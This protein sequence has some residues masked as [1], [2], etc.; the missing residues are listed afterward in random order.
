MYTNIPSLLDLLSIPL[1]SSYSSRSPQ[2]TELSFLWTF[3]FNYT[4][5]L[6]LSHKAGITVLI[7]FRINQM[8]SCLYET[9]RGGTGYSPGILAGTEPP[10]RFFSSNRFPKTLNCRV[11][12]SKHNFHNLLSC[13]QVRVV[14]YEPW[15]TTFPLWLQRRVGASVIQ[16]LLHAYGWTI[17][18]SQLHIGFDYWLPKSL[19]KCLAWKMLYK[20]K[21]EIHILLF[22]LLKPAESVV[23]SG[24]LPSRGGK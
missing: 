22:C 7:L 12:V 15:F 4:K 24:Y 16:G 20:F 11:Q 18:V 19:G 5:S 10:Y 17:S 23:A 1:P 21:V 2:N 8:R 6:S 13:N 3:F 9:L 14:I